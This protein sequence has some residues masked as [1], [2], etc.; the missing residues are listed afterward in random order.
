MPTN[1]AKRIQTKQGYPEIVYVITVAGLGLCTILVL[2]YIT[3]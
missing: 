2:A 1:Y 3:A